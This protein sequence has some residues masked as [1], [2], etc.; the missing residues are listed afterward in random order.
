[1]QIFTVQSPPTETPAHY[2]KFKVDGGIPYRDPKS[3]QFGNVKKA[4][5]HKMGRRSSISARINKGK[6]N[7]RPDSQ[8]SLGYRQATPQQSPHSSS[9]QLQGGAGGGRGRGRGRGG[10]SG[11]AGRTGTRGGG[12]TGTRG[13]GRGGG[14]RG[15]GRQPGPASPNE[16]FSGFGSPSS[17]G[18]PRADFEE[19]PM[20]EE[21]AEISPKRSK[22]KDGGKGSKKKG[23]KGLNAEEWI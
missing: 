15:R 19:Q 21:V 13:G 14:G 1:M 20:Y 6:R 5:G 9:S 2:T 4:L 22:S 10:R 23:G 18:S 11:P 12:R 3:L 8:S 7:V 16:S 17:L